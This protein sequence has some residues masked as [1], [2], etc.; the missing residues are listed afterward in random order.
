MREDQIAALFYGVLVV[1]FFG[2][3]WIRLRNRRKKRILLTDYR[4]GV[5]FVNGTFQE[6]LG[7]G[8]YRYDE[9]NEQ[10][11]VMDLRPQPILIERLTFQDA[12][13]HEGIISVGT[14]LLVRDPRLAA[15]ALRDQIKDAYVM[16]RD[17]IRTAMSKQIAASPEETSSVTK[18]ITEAVN[19][20][21]A[22][23]GIAVS[24]IEITELVSL[25]PQPQAG[26]GS[27][28]IQ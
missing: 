5:H 19:A 11:A 6:V 24:E 14:E 21:L 10:I 15:T 28:T 9:R 4:R 18:A 16:V 27:T 13:R 23:V 22:K 1:T 17:T 25:S 8:S 7:P 26:I 20:E 3:S 2:V 12:L